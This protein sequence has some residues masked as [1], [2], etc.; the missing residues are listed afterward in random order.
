M[1]ENGVGLG[2][3]RVQVRMKNIQ[4]DAAFRDAAMWRTILIIRW[5]RIDL[6]IAPMSTG[7]KTAFTLVFS[8]IKK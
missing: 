7:V 8:I 5:G 1:S 4:I 3:I 2:P 6:K